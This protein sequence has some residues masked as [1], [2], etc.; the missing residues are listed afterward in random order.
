MLHFIIYINLLS[1]LGTCTVFQTYV[2]I[3]TLYFLNIDYMRCI[4]SLACHAW[5][6]YFST[7]HYVGFVRDN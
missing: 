5:H 7:P 2:I 4:N 6:K 1:V 3:I